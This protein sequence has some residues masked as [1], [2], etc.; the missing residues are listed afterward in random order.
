MTKAKSEIDKIVGRL[1]KLLP[2][3][4]PNPE[5]G[6]GTERCKVDR[7]WVTAA[8]TLPGKIQRLVT[9]LNK[10]QDT[11][12]SVLQAKN[13][14]LES[15][16]VRIKELDTEIS[17]ANAKILEAQR[18]TAKCKALIEEKDSR[19]KELEEKVADAALEKQDEKADDEA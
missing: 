12:Q 1:K 10:A 2:A 13:E 7:A 19:I 17:D 3:D 6:S 15:K 11:I 5:P 4:G 14:E 16:D 18:E 8:L 9:D